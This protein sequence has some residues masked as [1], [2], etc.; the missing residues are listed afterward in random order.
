MN[1]ADVE[2][3]G[4]GVN[5]ISGDVGCERAG[6]VAA[7]SECLGSGAEKFESGPGIDGSAFA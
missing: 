1:A 7:V 2:G 5:D 4:V 6:V 3:T